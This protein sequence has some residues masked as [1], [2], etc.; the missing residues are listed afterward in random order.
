M[1]E[2]EFFGT[3]ETLVSMAWTILH[4]TGFMEWVVVII[5]KQATNAP[6]ELLDQ[7]KG[8]D[9]SSSDISINLSRSE[10]LKL[11]LAAS[12]KVRTILEHEDKFDLSAPVSDA[13]ARGTFETNLDLL[14]NVASQGFY[15]LGQ[16]SV[17]SP[18]LRANPSIAIP[19]TYDKG[20]L[21][22]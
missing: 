14:A 9:V 22:V 4:L 16:M 18:T 3:G 7:F 21:L 13:K 12:S 5:T 10:V 19:T 8:G 11:F 1:S 2:A 6:I 17:A 20:S 15:H